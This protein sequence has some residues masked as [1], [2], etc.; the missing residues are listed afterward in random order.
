MLKIAVLLPGETTALGEFLADAR[1][2][3]TAGAHALWLDQGLHDIKFDHREDYGGAQISLRWRAE[4]MPQTTFSPIPSANF[5][6]AGDAGTA[7]YVRSGGDNGNDRG[8]YVWQTP[9][10]AGNPSVD[11]TS[12]GAGRWG[13][14]TTVMMVPSFAPDASKLVF[15]D[16]DSGGGNGWRKGLSTFQF[17]QAGK[18][19]KN[20]KTIVSTWPTGDVL[21]WPVFES[22]SRS[23]IYQATVPAD[24][25]CR[26]TS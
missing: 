13:L 10:A 16:G 26:R 1:A 12:Q 8:Y 4:C 6:P 18:M 5:Y 3:D 21:K 20:R 19:F 9:S 24:M 15:I 23:V 2:L 25:C 17:D 22:D 7:G 14:G 11:V